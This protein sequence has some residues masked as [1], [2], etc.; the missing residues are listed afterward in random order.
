MSVSGAVRTR[1]G[2]IDLMSLAEKL[3]P[4]V[5]GDVVDDAA[6]LKTYSRDTSIFEKKP[7]VVVFPKD[8]EDV[9]AVVRF[10]ALAR[11]RGE[12]VSVTPRAA[13]TD[14]TG[15]PLSS[16]IV[17]SFTKYM[18]RVEVGENEAVTEPGTFYRD[19]EKATKAKGGYILPS[20]PP[21]PRAGA[22]RR[23]TRDNRAGRPAPS[24]P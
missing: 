18:N 23:P 17:L 6:T 11:A 22:P 21:P 8:K 9:A 20:Y 13:G 14:M 19:F 24:F 5:Q 10:A 1:R 16:S 15:G 4:L 12:N 7:V 3:R 2:T